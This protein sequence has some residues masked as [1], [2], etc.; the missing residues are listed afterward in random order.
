MSIVMEYVEIPIS[1]MKEDYREV[2]KHCNAEQAVVITRYG[3]KRYVIIE[4]SKFQTIIEKT[5]TS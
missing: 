4:Y 5:A 1:Q 3:K 2:V